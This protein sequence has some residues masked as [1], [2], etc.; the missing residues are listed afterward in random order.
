[1]R[2]IIFL[3]S[4]ALTECSATKS[5][6]NTEIP[7]QWDIGSDWTKYS[8]NHQGSV[9]LIRILLTVTLSTQ[10]LARPIRD[11]HG[12]KILRRDF[13]FQLSENNNVYAITAS[14][15]STI[16]SLNPNYRKELNQTSEILF[17]MNPSERKLER[18]SSLSHAETHRCGNIEKFSLTDEL[19]DIKKIF[20]TYYLEFHNDRRSRSA[21]QK[22]INR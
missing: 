10:A 14:K 13:P 16:S 21:C 7:Q 18:L 11:I 1:M 3:L 12:Q 2:I 20:T 9:M 4:L 17:F 8:A 5:G 15:N 19:V 22:N 6:N